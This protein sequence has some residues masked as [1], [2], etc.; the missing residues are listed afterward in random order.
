MAILEK[1]VLVRAAAARR[2]DG[3]PVPPRDLAL[4]AW[5]VYRQA[6]GPPE[7]W[8][9]AAG[10]WKPAATVDPATVKPTPLMS[11]EGDPFPWQGVLMAAAAPPDATGTPRYQKSVAGAP[12]YF[13]RTYF[14]STPEAGGLVGLSAASA[15]VQFVGFTDSLRAGLAVGEGETPSSATRVGMFLRDA[16]LQSIG[17][18]EIESAGPRSKVEVTN[19]TGAAIVL[20]PN[21][22]VE[23][24]PSPGRSILLAGPLEAG[25]VT[26]EPAGAPGT[27]DTL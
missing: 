15:G 26:F 17:R 4:A 13:V 27:R 23:V 24:R 25:R 10:R 9:E 7:V 3:T 14:V 6:A 8:D 2:P 18:I 1:P 12:S 22:D 20:L 16:S 21:G 19:G 5:L 11:K